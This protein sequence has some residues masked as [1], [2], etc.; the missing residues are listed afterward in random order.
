M[1]EMF[2]TQWVKQ[3][4]N[5]G[6]VV[7]WSDPPGKVDGQDK[8]ARATAMNESTHMVIVSKSSAL[9]VGEEYTTLPH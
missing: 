4:E 5:G 8:A 3:L 1:D 7:L 6:Y 2:V 9:A